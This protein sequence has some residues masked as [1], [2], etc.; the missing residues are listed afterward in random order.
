[1]RTKWS[2]FIISI[3]IFS[4][5][6]QKD[7]DELAESPIKFDP[8]PL[9]IP[10][11]NALMTRWGEKEVLKS[12]LIDDFESDLN[13]EVTGI[14]EMSYTEDR[15][16]DGKRSL[17]FRTSL[18]DE[19]YYRRT[20]TE[21]DSF[22]GSQGG[23]SRVELTFDEPQDWSDFNRISFWI[24]VHE[25]SMP[26]YCISLTMRCKDAIRNATTYNEK[27]NV[28]QDLKP[29]EW[30]HV[31]FEIPH[32]QRD[33][34]TSFVINQTLRGHNPEE[35]GIVTYDID[36]LEIQKV[37]ADMYEGW[38]VAPDKFAFCH[39]G[40]RTDEPKVALVTAGAGK[41]FQLVDKDDK[42]VFSGSVEVVEN[43][44]GVFNVLDF[45]EFSEGGEYRLRCGSLE[46]NPFP[47][48]DEI[49]I[50]PVFKAMNFF[51]CQRCGFH[52]PGVHLECHK[53]W[54][55]FH[56]NVK[57]IINGGWHDAG[58]LSQ[59]SF[60]TAMST[61]SMMMHLER[62]DKQPEYAELAHRIREEIAWGL[63]WLLKT[64]FGDGY[65][66]SFSVMRIYTDNEVGTID[67][68]VSPARNVPWEN[69]L[70]S[71]VQAKASM[72]LGTSHP[73]LAQQSKT[74]VLEDWQAA[75]D[76]VSARNQVDYREAAWGAT[77]SMVLS[78]MTGDEKY[79]EH[80]I[81]FGQMLVQCQEQQ[82]VDGIPITGYFYT[83]TD[84]ER[85]IHNYHAAFEEAPLIA[86][87]MLC[88]EFPN[89]EDW[90][91]WYS[92]AV[93]HSEFFMKR[94]SKIAAPY[95]LLP[96][97]VW[98]KK[99]I[100]TEEVPRR[101]GRESSAEESKR[102]RT[103]RLRQFNDGTSLNDEYVLRTFPI[104]HDNLFHGNTNIH[105]SS[106]WAL[107]EA[108]RLRKDASGMQLVGKQFRWLFGDNPFSQSLMYGVGYDFAPHFAYCLKDLVGALPVG[109]D[110][111]SGDDPHWSATNT[112][113]YKE[114]WVEP[115]N[116]FL[117]AM[118]IYLSEISGSSDEQETEAS[119]Q[120]DTETMQMGDGVVKAAITATGT[121]EHVLTFRTYNVQSD[122][123]EIQIIFSGNNPEKLELE[124][125]IPDSGKPYIVVINA[126][127]DPTLQWEVVG[128]FVDW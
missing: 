120:L 47:I 108:S 87:A 26:T 106:T 50:Q 33:K 105:M 71:A 18:R 5:T 126:D 77:S 48:D 100:L 111:H 21:W 35:E 64:R 114:I 91:D 128:A 54:Q 72:M 44:E 13:W 102:W 63:E 39:V 121:G 53:D 19:E 23:Y 59:G 66:M 94:G 119:I 28:V 60:R 117:G 116:R 112:A 73:E 70:A 97:S 96:N 12:E 10:E 17:R 2:L 110:C 3:I 107:A 90:M 65:H 4:C 14:G 16:R 67:D 22:G 115:V 29:G 31:M 27:S 118:A 30:N 46:S 74:A 51:W 84:R 89:H 36:Q 78:K 49:W 38:K 69:F 82:F 32:L 24:F 55:G 122:P 109:M 88:R 8:F 124:L 81:K 83:T 95:E 25:T 15:A 37:E 127:Q 11:Q 6:T 9:E 93:L 7:A 20:R 104:Y 75:I 43:K 56:G 68:V 61:L 42:V 45:S 85:V 34:V 123:G 41:E 57:K 40:Y 1:M 79:R 92:A 62:L 103:D 58:D 125:D 99:E 76:V 101:R 86:L 98:K 80:A 52:V 113:T